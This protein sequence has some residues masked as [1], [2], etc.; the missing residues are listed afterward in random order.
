MQQSADIKELIDAILALAYQIKKLR[1]E[2][3]YR[4]QQNEEH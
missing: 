4:D 2:L 3:E 1:E